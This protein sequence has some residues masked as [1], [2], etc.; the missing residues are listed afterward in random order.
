MAITN[1]AIRVPNARKLIVYIKLDNND[2]EI[3]R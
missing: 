2:E 1:I 3:E